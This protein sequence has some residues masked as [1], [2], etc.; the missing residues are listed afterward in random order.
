MIGYNEKGKPKYKTFTNKQRAI[1]AKRLADFISN[2]EK[3]KSIVACNQT[4]SQ[5]LDTWYNEYVVNRLKIS[6]RVNYESI[7]INHIKP[8]IGHIK[9]VALKKTDIETMYRKLAENGKVGGTGGLS[10]KSMK[11]VRIVLH[12]ALEEAYR[13]EYI[14]KNPASIAKLPTLNATDT[15]KKEISVLSREEQKV[16]LIACS[17]DVYGA[18]VF[19]ALHTG[20]RLGELL[21]L[22]WDDIDFENKTIRINKQVNRL[23]NYDKNS[24]AKTCLGIQYSTKTAASNRVISMS[25]PLADR[26]N[27]YKEMQETEKQFWDNK[28][29][30]LNMVF[31]RWDGNYMDPAT[32]RDR[33]RAILKE[34]GLKP[35]TVHALRHTFATR[36]LEAGIAIKV[37][38]KLLGHTSIE[39]TMDTYSHVLP[40]FQSEAMNRIAEYYEEMA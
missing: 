35:F 20:I 40:E 9:L 33:Y 17:Y 27:K 30:D 31:A 28:Y 4:I 34:A 26:L 14:I 16:L 38:S 10:I 7:I 29:N 1:V 19:T 13:R 12:A 15:R 11:G 6:T 23:K 8:Y 2:R 32:F 21:G 39:I 25:G 3:A 22:Q 36:A 24:K 5:W 18:A 37:V